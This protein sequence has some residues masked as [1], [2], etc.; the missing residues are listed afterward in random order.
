M[1][2][3]VLMN[4]TFTAGR[5]YRVVPVGSCLA[6]CAMLSCLL[7]LLRP[8]VVGPMGL[9]ASLAFAAAYALVL[10]LLFV[11]V[12][13]C[14]RHR[15]QLDD[16]RVISNG[17]LAVTE[18]RL[19]DVTDVVWRPDGLGGVALKTNFDKVR[20][21]FAC[22]PSDASLRM[23]A[24]LR[25]TLAK[26][27]QRNWD[28]F[29]LRVG[30]PLRN[31]ASP[32]RRLEVLFSR[33]QFDRLLSS[34]FFAEL[35]Y[36]TL[37]GFPGPGAMNVLLPTLTGLAWIS[38]RSLV[39]A[40]YLTKAGCFPVALF[41][42][43][44]VDHL[45]WGFRLVGLVMLCCAFLVGIPRGLELSIAVV[46]IAGVLELSR[47]SLKHWRDYKEQREHDVAHSEAAVR[48]WELLDRG[49]A[50]GT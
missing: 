3:A 29:C 8:A 27:E 40:T 50:L 33:A 15:L 32:S 9:L 39:P 2:D 45:A 22:Y 47:Q 49:H 19:A 31:P 41:V 48:E 26:S 23:I 44:L 18:I 16:E 35:A 37:N 28:R 42:E 21:N 13:F 12:L 38:A 11:H 4:E 46:V 5:W 10:G 24:Y 25:E 36:G 6:F 14:W 34:L 7:F 30:I 17:L 20:L 1:N 43:V